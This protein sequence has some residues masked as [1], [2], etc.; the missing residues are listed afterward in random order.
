MSTAENYYI[1]RVVR[2]QNLRT[3]LVLRG[4]QMSRNGV[5]TDSR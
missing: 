1:V 2:T 4:L 3:T 5:T